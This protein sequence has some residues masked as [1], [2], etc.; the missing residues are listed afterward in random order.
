MCIHLS[1]AHMPAINLPVATQFQVIILLGCFGISAVQAH[2]FHGVSA[3]CNGEN[4]KNQQ[5]SSREISFVLQVF[6]RRSNGP[7]GLLKTALFRKRRKD[8]VGNA[9]QLEQ[10]HAFARTKRATIASQ[11]KGAFC[12]GQLCPGSVVRTRR[13]RCN[14]FR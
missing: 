8:P 13:S 6:S 3:R 2:I 4:I 9:H 10:L 7:T 5:T 1:L 11:N 12:I 14:C